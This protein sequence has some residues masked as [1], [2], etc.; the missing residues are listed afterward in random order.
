MHYFNAILIILFS[1]ELFLISTSPISISYPSP[2]SSLSPF[3]I[4]YNNRKFL[5]TS[6]GVFSII[7]TTSPF[8]L[9]SSYPEFSSDILINSTVSEYSYYPINDTHSLFILPFINNAIFC[10][11]Y[12]R[13]TTYITNIP[14]SYQLLPGT[15]P[16]I[17]TLFDGRVIISFVESNEHHGIIIIVSTDLKIEGQ[18]QTLFDIKDSIFTCKYFTFTSIF[19][20]L[21]GTD[22]NEIRY[23]RFTYVGNLR[24]ER[25]LGKVDDSHQTEG[26][27]IYNIDN[28]YNYGVYID[29]V[30]HRLHFF[31][32]ELDLVTVYYI[33]LKETKESDFYIDDYYG[34]YFFALNQNVLFVSGSYQGVYHC[35]LFYIEN[36]YGSLSMDHFDY[37][38]HNGYHL[39]IAFHENILAFTYMNKNTNDILF[40]EH[41]IQNCLSFTLDIENDNAISFTNEDLLEEYT[42]NEIYI[43]IKNSNSIDQLGKWYDN[44]NK[45]IRYDT[46]FLFDT[47]ITYIPQYP[48]EE[49]YTYIIYFKKDEKFYIPTPQCFFKM[50]VKCYSSCSSCDEIGN[51]ANHKCT[52]CIRNYHP[53]EF[54]NNCYTSQIDGYYYDSL[55]EIYKKCIQNCKHCTDGNN[56]DNCNEGFTLLSEY[57]KN[58]NDIKCVPICNTLYYITES[59][60][61]I[62]INDSKICPSNYPCYDSNSNQCYKFTDSNCV[63]TMPHVKQIDTIQS[64][65]D[66]NIISLYRTN[67]SYSNWNYSA[68]VYD[69]SSSMSYDNLTQIDLKDCEDRIR[70]E[71]KIEEETP[72][73]IGQVEYVDDNDV[74]YSFYLTDG[75]KI[76]MSICVND[77]V[78]I[79]SKIDEEDL[80]VSQEKIELLHKESIDVFNSNDSFFNDNC[81]EFSDTIDETK[82]DITI[83]DRRKKYYQNITL[84]RENC[85]YSSTDI[86]T[87]KITFKCTVINN[88]NVLSFTGTKTNSF[89]SSLSD[90]TID[91]MLCFDKIG[92]I[93][94]ISKSIGNYIML[95]IFIIQTILLFVYLC[96][97]KQMYNSFLT[98]I[99]NEYNAER[100]KESF[101]EIKKSEQNI[102]IYEKPKVL[103]PQFRTSDNTVNITN[104][105][106]VNSLTTDNNKNYDKKS[107]NNSDYFDGLDFNDSLIYDT[108]TFASY[109]KTT[110]KKFSIVYILCTPNQ[111]KIKSLFIS[112]FLFFVSSTLF[113]NV[114]YYNDKYISHIYYEGYKFSYEFPKYL[115]SSLSTLG[116]KVIIDLIAMKSFPK[117]NNINEDI[118]KSEKE[119]KKFVNKMKK[120][121]CIVLF[122]IIGCSLFFWCFI[123]VFCCLY[124]NTQYYWVYGSLFSLFVDYIIVVLLVLLCTLLRMISLRCNNEFFYHIAKLIENW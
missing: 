91:I 110:Y 39:K 106:H 69:S 31:A 20:C 62:C 3:Y 21:F 73:I 89:S 22:T 80:T 116:V 115:Y 49:H 19:L 27:K 36:N 103:G 12:I 124:T 94:L 114:L 30:T 92:K 45:I 35:R 52:D 29:K 58:I 87:M 5:F 117:K 95:T 105:S 118:Y 28:V 32:F 24:M 44:N 99:S 86:N 14:I 43:I 6:Q 38:A 42:N 68:L 9:K 71:Y 40:Y 15:Q 26:I 59:N 67:F 64:Y 50:R 46:L 18:G 78:A 54:T 61:F 111:Y 10:K 119:K 60:D 122:I 55:V 102:F 53:V 16:N 77:S 100:N 101:E 4:F 48:Q 41:K 76:N 25:T 37:C 112:T 51:E 82:R 7:T 75:R 8:T 113:F 1:Y 2:S 17:D 84:K 109:Y 107:N 57:T 34:Y 98:M 65:I 120:C 13:K 74:F 85:E 11:A 97:R 88:N 93:K 96:Q 108:R 104:L 63:I 121:N 23:Y 83:V 66:D 72:L 56:C 33:T 123:S 81:F 79:E 70:E 47:P 90:S